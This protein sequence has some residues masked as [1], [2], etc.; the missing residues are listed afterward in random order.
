[1]DH[2]S[3]APAQGRSGLPGPGLRAELLNEGQHSE[4]GHMAS[5]LMDGRK[6]FGVD[7]A[8]RHE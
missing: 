3:A 6:H 2:T 5:E 8:V 7:V 1:M 4:T